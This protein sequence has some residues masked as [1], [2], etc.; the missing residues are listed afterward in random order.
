MSDDVIPVPDVSPARTMGRAAAQSPLMR[1]LL[2][3]GV[4]LLV[5]TLLI[6]L[7]GKDPVAAYNAFVQGA[8][9]SFDRV[10]VALN[11]STPYILSG[12]GV[13]LCFRA[14]VINI[15]G[16]GQIAIGGLAAAWVAL[17][18][19]FSS[20]LAAL[21]AA[22]VAGALGGMAWAGVATL[23][24]LLRGVHEVLVTL[25]LNFVAILLVMQVLQGPLG[26][27]GAGFPQSPLLPDAY[28]LP[29]LVARTDLHIGILLAIAAAVAAHIYLWRTVG[30]FRLRIVGASRAAA[31]Y[32]GFSAARTTVLVMMMGGGL[33]GL[34]GA[35]EVLGLHNRLIAGFSQGFGFNAVAIALLGALNPLMVVPAGLFFGFLEAGALAMQR[36][37]GIPSSLV[38]VVEGTIMLCVLVAMA[39]GRR[40]G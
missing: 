36:Q 9:G 19:P 10:V 34:A 23:I 30:G 29:K 12:V 39:G 8:F 26:E 25:L 2:A 20:P 17:S 6:A 14:N 13:A 22:I 11:K 32:S 7:S 27:A 28:W 33:S 4:G 16:E 31:A 24:H 18:L 5:S 35:V 1:G 21:P 3:I 15:G 40:S 37:I 38:A